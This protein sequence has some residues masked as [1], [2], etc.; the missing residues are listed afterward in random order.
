MN[1]L[2]CASLPSKK[3]LLN[4]NFR[5]VAEVGLDGRDL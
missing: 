1:G 2:C 3:T 5:A 4:L